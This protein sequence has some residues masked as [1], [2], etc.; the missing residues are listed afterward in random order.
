MK[1]DGVQ[2][3]ETVAQVRGCSTFLVLAGR[4]E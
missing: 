3:S 1:R 2:D 4:T